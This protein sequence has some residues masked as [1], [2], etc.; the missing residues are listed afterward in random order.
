M[1]Q[2]AYLPP[3]ASYGQ[4]PR[5]TELLARIGPISSRPYASLLTWLTRRVPPGCVVLTLSARDPI[6]FIPAIQRLARSGYRVEHVAFGDDAARHAAVVRHAGL[7]ASSAALDP[8][9]ESA[10]ALVLA[11]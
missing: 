8:N 5:L 6:T 7:P 9:W 2:L 10:D 11:G 3:R 4:L 1:Q